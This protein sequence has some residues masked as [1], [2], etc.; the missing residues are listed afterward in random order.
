MFTRSLP[1]KARAA[2]GIARGW[3]AGDTRRSA[4]LSVSRL[5]GRRGLDGEGDSVG[6]A[7]EQIAANA[8]TGR[9]RQYHRNGGQ[10]KQVFHGKESFQLGRTERGG[11]AQKPRRWLAVQGAGRGREFA[12]F[13]FT[14]TLH[15]AVRQANQ[16]RELAALF[17]APAALQAWH[18]FATTQPAQFH[19]VPT[20][21]SGKLYQVAPPQRRKTQLD[22][23]W[24]IGET[25]GVDCRPGCQGR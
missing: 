2:A 10:G 1:L 14:Q 18:R 19:T 23:S 24:Q 9:T 4:R 16:R 25:R 22:G 12:G 20:L 8:A 3:A 7:A 13:A 6:A 15:R 21:R 17:L 11:T 5:I